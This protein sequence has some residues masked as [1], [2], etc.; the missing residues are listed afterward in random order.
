LLAALAAP[1]FAQIANTQ[2]KVVKITSETDLKNYE[3][4]QQ[5]AD[6]SAPNAQIPNKIN[7]SGKVAEEEYTEEELQKI[8]EWYGRCAEE[9]PTAFRSAN[10]DKSPKTNKK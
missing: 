2:K 9:N 8:L 5:T 1:T 10:K 3:K 6:K 4:S 7:H